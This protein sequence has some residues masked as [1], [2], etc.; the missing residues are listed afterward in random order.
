ILKDLQMNEYLRESA[1]AGALVQETLAPAH[2]GRN[3]G[4]R[5]SNILAVLNTARRPAILVEMGFSSHRN[6]ARFLA[7]GAGQ[8]KIARGIADAIVKYLLEF[9]RRSGTDAATEGR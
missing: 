9:E 4:V 7:S 8:R 2:P 1:R 3:L 6:D 5:Q